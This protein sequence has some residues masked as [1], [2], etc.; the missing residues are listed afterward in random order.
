ME[1]LSVAELTLMILNILL[2]LIALFGALVGN[3]L[4]RA[5]NELKETDKA[6]AAK[7]EQYARREDLI[8]IKNLVSGIFHRLDDIRDKV[9]EKPSRS[10]LEQMRQEIRDVRS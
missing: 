9:A 4:T 10:E 6:L 5:I 8:E 1:G 7:F 3:N 2:A